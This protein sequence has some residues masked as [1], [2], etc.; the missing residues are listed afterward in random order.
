MYNVLRLSAQLMKVYIHY[1]HICY[2]LYWVHHIK[3]LQS[4]MHFC[5]I[6]RLKARTE[7]DAYHCP[8]HW[9][10][11]SIKMTRFGCLLPSHVLTLTMPESMFLVP[12]KHGSFT[13][14]HVGDVKAAGICMGFDKNTLLLGPWVSYMILN[15]RLKKMYL[16][17]YEGIIVS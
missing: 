5:M 12:S 6:T 14:M 16:K 3:V 9:C 7:C 8:C 13:N 2:R 15:S 4:K 11:R 10:S 17:T 1:W